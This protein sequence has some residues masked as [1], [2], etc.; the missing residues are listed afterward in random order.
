MKVGFVSI[1]GR[2]NAG[3]STLIKIITGISLSDK[4]NITLNG[5]NLIDNPL[6]Y[7]KSFGYVADDYNS[8]I[9]LTGLEYLN[10]MAD[11]Y[12]IDTIKRKKQID[13]LTT[14]LNIKKDLNNMIAS[15]S[16]GMKQKIKI[17]GALLH[18]PKL[19]ILDEPF[20]G[21]D[22][23]S[24]YIVKSLLKDMVSRGH[25]VLLT[26]HILEIAENLSDTLLILNN[27][28]VAF[29]SNVDKCNYLNLEEFFLN[30]IKG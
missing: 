22:A 13:M 16:K 9:H 11:I 6:E 27:G 25:T 1:V 15:Y 4:G 30:L 19:L 12:N 2:P 20:N 21:L 29:N 7:K 3:K 5:Y 8:F 26:T 17:I 24:V 14:K 23:E 10:F 18:E 28:K